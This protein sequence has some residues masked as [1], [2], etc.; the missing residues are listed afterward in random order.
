MDQ[1]AVLRNTCLHS[2]PY[3]VVICRVDQDKQMAECK[4]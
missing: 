4:P 1:S 2:K 3:S